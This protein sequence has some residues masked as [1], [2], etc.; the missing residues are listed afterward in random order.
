[1]SDFEGGVSKTYRVIQKESAILWE[2][3]VCVILRKKVY[4]NM[5]PILDSYG[6]MT[7]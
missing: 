3:I 6:V 4:I 7:V 5:C 2:T 1:M